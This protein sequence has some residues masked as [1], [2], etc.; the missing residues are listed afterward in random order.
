MS[1]R[2]RRAL[3][4]CSCAALGIVGLCIILS[5]VFL[6]TSCSFNKYVVAAGLPA[7]DTAFQTGT[8]VGYN[9]YIWECY[10]GKRIVLYNET[11]EM[12]AG[13]FKREEAPCQGT[14]DIEKAL[15]NVSKRALN[16]KAFW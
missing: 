15:A 13:P 6:F 14:T 2:S 7:P 4:G 9:V 16:P 11:S 8:V 3:F 1:R 5:L 10:Q 12:R